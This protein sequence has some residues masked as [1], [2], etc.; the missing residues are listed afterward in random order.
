M[1][2]EQEKSTLDF[3]RLSLLFHQGIGINLTTSQAIHEAGR[4]AWNVGPQRLV[5]YRLLNLQVAIIRGRSRKKKQQSTSSLS[6]L[7]KVV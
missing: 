2:Q 3:W 4:C 5:H 7:H 1:S 6:I